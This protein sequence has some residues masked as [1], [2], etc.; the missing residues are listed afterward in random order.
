M[1][2]NFNLKSFLIHGLRRLSYRYPPRH[3]AYNA[4]KSGRN[5]YH[6]INHPEKIFK[7]KEVQLDHIQPVVDPETGFTTFDDYITRLFCDESGFQV[8]CIPCHK[9]KTE[10][11]RR[12]RINTRRKKK[13]EA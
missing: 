9:K 7:R 5:Q 3:A 13:E 10:K 4:A 8:L 11:E 1:P 12:V 6:C 2:R